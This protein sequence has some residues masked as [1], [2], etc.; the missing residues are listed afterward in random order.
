MCDIYGILSEKIKKDKE[1]LI[2]RLIRNLETYENENHT[3]CQLWK[4]A[5]NYSGYGLIN[6]KYQKRHVQLKVHRVFLVLALKRPIAENMEAGHTCPNGF[7]HCVSHLTEQTRTENLRERDEKN[8][9]ERD[10]RKRRE[11]RRSS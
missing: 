5:K 3:P 10:R 8:R 7:R 2:T 9:E 1:R 4:G 11:E 6:F